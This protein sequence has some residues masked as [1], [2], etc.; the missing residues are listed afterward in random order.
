MARSN[1]LLLMMGFRLLNL[2][3]LGIINYQHVVLLV[4]QHLAVTILVK[5]IAIIKVSNLLDRI[6]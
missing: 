5:A 3:I 1:Q 4:I 2:L 6:W